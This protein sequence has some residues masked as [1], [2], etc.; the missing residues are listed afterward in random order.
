MSWSFAKHRNFQSDTPLPH[1][2]EWVSDELETKI[3]EGNLG[4][5]TVLHQEAHTERDLMSNVSIKPTT[6]EAL[7]LTTSFKKRSA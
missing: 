7:K 6:R 5:A 4:Q 1:K 3:S 2:V